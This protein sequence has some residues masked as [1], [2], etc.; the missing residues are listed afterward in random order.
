MNQDTLTQEKDNSTLDTS[1]PRVKFTN[2]Y[3]ITNDLENPNLDNVI[4]SVSDA[5]E[6][7]ARL[8]RFEKHENLKELDEKALKSLTDTIPLPAS[9]EE[10]EKLGTE[11]KTKDLK[12]YIL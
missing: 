7:S 8:I 12:K 6:W 1:V 2:R 11:T 10:L 3:I 5:S 9:M 4:A